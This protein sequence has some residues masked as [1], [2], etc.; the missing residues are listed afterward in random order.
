M[1]RYNQQRKILGGR[2]YGFIELK[3]VLN[4]GVDF[5]IIHEIDGRDESFEGAD[6]TGL[7]YRARI[8]PRR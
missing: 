6:K 2:C 4:F 7:N 8:R 1:A 5:S 3:T